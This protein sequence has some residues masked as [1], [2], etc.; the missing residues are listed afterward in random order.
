MITRIPAIA[1]ANDWCPSGQ[2]PRVVSEFAVDETGIGVGL[3]DPLRD[4]GWSV[5]GV[6]AGTRSTM[7]NEY[8][9]LISE[10]YMEDGKHAIKVCS[11]R[12]DELLISQLLQRQFEF[13]QSSKQRR[14]VPKDVLRKK[15]L[16]SPDRADAFILAFADSRKL[17][18]GSGD[19]RESLSLF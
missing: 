10:L 3:V 2:D 19:W 16:G 12:N 18:L 13:F 1:I 14:L 7:P 17:D 15:G 11:I 8:Y 6:H 9:N 5:C 4:L